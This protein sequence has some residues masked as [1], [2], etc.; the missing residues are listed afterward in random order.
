[1]KEYEER[2]K[3]VK[4]PRWDKEKEEYICQHCGGVVSA[5][6]MAYR[7]DCPNCKKPIHDK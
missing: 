7:Y 2:N 1:M 4:T 5:N 6:T 3:H